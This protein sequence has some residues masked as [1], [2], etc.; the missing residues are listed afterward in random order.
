MFHRQERVR[1][2]LGSDVYEPVARQDP[3]FAGRGSLLAL[4]PAVKRQSSR[5]SFDTIAVKL[6][7]SAPLSMP[8][9]VRD[10]LP[11]SDTN[12]Q[13]LIVATRRDRAAHL[14]RLTEPITLE[15]QIRADTGMNHRY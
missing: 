15:T 14:L 4:I 8:I 11:P 7:Q 10:R 5:M 13:T 3:R 12:W 2:C 6:T 9:S 1:R